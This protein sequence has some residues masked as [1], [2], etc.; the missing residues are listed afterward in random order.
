MSALNRLKE[1]VKNVSLAAALVIATAL[2]SVAEAQM[3][4]QRECARM[5]ENIGRAAG[6]YG[7]A[8]KR[9]AANLMTALLGVVGNVTGSVM[10]QNGQAPQEQYPA[11]TAR[12]GDQYPAPVYER[13]R[14]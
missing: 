7:A 6:Q 13:R 3:Y 2:P 8:G 1:E 10:C 4:Q 9:E 14:Y 5:G 11:R 12:T